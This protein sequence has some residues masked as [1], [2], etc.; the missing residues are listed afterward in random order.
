[1]K[2]ILKYLGIFLGLLMIMFVILYFNN[3]IGINKTNIEREAL[4]S[5]KIP[6]DWEVCKDETE[7]LVSMLFYDNKLEN[8]IFSIY[9]NRKG[10]S[11]GY[12]FREGGSLGGMI[13]NVV[14]FNIEGFNEKI[15]MSTNKNEVCK[16]EL[17]DGNTIK[18]IDIDST[19][20]FTVILP[21]NL[22]TVTI[23]DVNGNSVESVVY[24]KKIN[25]VYHYLFFLVLYISFS[26]KAIC[27]L[28]PVKI[29]QIVTRGII[30]IKKI[31][32]KIPIINPPYD[33]L[34][35]LYI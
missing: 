3:D 25:S 5:Q 26:N 12:F 21:T 33:I 15:Y 11:F 13:D 19:K 20:P 23:Y 16:I 9:V 24:K 18:V 27:S 30:A 35:T 10:L 31:L 8:H 29:I 14:E 32:F 4:I 7:S 6:T 1:M 2:S 34:I 22:G 17:N 28:S